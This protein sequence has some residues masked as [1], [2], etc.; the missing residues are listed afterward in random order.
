MTRTRIREE[1]RDRI[2]RDLHDTLLQSIQGLLLT[3]QA[4]SR[5]P[6]EEETR[7]ALVRAVAVARRAVADSRDKVGTLRAGD[8]PP[9]CPMILLLEELE[10]ESSTTGKDTEV[11]LEGHVRELAWEVTEEIVAILREA[12]TNARKHAQASRIALRVSF[13]KRHLVAIVQDDG[14]GIGS[15]VLDR[16]VREGHFGLVGMRERAR[17]IGARFQIASAP[18]EGTTVTLKVRA[19]CAYLRT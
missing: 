2:A 9:V 11:V 7:Q 12:L 8:A 15:H 3:L 4:I 16:G 6:M 10:A 5:Q 14:V 13:E 19:K 18:G 17:R 1:E